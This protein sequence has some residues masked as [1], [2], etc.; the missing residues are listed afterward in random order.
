M[1]TRKFTR[2]NFLKFLS[3]GLLVPLLST[4]TVKSKADQTIKL[5]TPASLA[6]LPVR[7]A[8]GQG[9]FKDHGLDIELLDIWK[10]SERMS[11]LASGRLDCIVADVTTTMLQ[12]ANSYARITIT[13]TAFY[14]VD[15]R[16]VLA[17]LGSGYNYKEVRTI[18][19]LLQR[20]SLKQDDSILIP[21]NSDVEFATD[22]LL[23]SLDF[24]LE[25]RRAYTDVVDYF[26]SF[27]QFIFGQYLAV[28]LPEPLATLAG[29]KNSFSNGGQL[30][31]G[32][33]G[34]ALCDYTEIE[35]LP[36]VVVFQDT[37]CQQNPGIIKKFFRAYEDTVTW[38]NQSSPEELRKIAANIGIEVFRREFHPNWEAPKGFEK[39]FDVPKFP[40]PR[41]LKRS[42][43]DNVLDWA[44]N[45]GYIRG[46][47]TI[48]YEDIFD[49]SFLS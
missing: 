18:E 47:K 40:P 21:R 36:A 41:A 49:G 8:E 13:G 35:L 14:K 43:F 20:I 44:T 45:K 9:F 27:S 11:F 26:Q 22:K 32:D 30:R 2:R 12:I 7:F 37:I 10:P 15:E 5:S 42:E 31:D 25:E 38:I 39:I 29:E 33:W 23:E 17:L 46:R 6:S 3:T 48:S 16:R 24:T 1:N 4:L 28:V 34:F 19:D